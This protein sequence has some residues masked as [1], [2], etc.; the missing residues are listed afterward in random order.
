M[1]GTLR[2][3][4]EGSARLLFR[5]DYREI[6]EKSNFVA[7]RISKIFSGCEMAKK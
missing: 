1:T 6:F 7:S 3:S 4:K 5:V 2:I